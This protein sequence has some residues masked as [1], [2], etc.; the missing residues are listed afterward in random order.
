MLDSAH[1][2]ASNDLVALP[3]LYKR[4]KTGA[5]QE[6]SIAVH[7]TGAKLGLIITRH[8]QHGGKLQEAS[9][10]ITEGKNLGKKNAT[11][12]VEQ[13][14]A[15]AQSKWEKQVKKGYVL[16]I[17]AA[18][19][20]EVDREFV[21]LGV[22]P[23][24]AEKYADHGE[25]VEYPADLQRKYD[26][27]RCEARIRKEDGVLDVTLW[28]RTRKPI[29]SVPHI[30][31]FLK[32]AFADAPNGFALDLDG[33]LYNHKLAKDFEKLTAILR[34]QKGVAAGA[35][36]MTYVVYDVVF[37]GWTWLARKAFLEGAFE[38]PLSGGPLVLAETFEVADEAEVDALV[39]GF[40]KEGFEGGV[41]RTH[42]G[43]YEK[44]ARSRSLLKVKRFDDAEFK[45]IGVEG[46]RGKMADKAVF[47]CETAK[48]GVFRAK[49]RGKLDALRVYLEHPERAVGRWLTVKFMGFTKKNNL[50][51]HGVGMRF[52]ED[53]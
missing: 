36:Q 8:G 49:M 5:M 25:D 10:L 45:V 11:D 34:K 41:L 23:M 40:I 3:K 31:E 33:E 32:K 35:E 4:G 26:G 24:L 18:M 30:V 29:E 20:G 1:L 51:R 47:I 42:M 13:A 43:V 17:E 52:R 19:A 44:G 22:A 7:R 9:D 48:G 12:A 16:T 6:W 39:E 2:I 21:G 53:L 37:D 27:H 46:G 28:S 14:M 15:E 50:P 38:G